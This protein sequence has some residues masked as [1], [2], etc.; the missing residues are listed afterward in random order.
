MN[1]FESFFASNFIFMSFFLFFI[2][3][4]VF[5]FIRNPRLRLNQLFVGVVV[6]SL[7]WVYLLFSLEDPLIQ[8][9]FK[10]LI[11]S[12]PAA[13]L[14]FIFITFQELE[15][16]MRETEDKSNTLL[17]KI[18][19]LLRTT[20]AIEMIL[21]ASLLLIVKIVNLFSTVEEYSALKSSL[22]SLILIVCILFAWEIILYSGFKLFTVIRKFWKEGWEIL[23]GWDFF[24]FQ[25][26]SLLLTFSCFYLALL[27]T[28]LHS[29]NFNVYQIIHVFGGLAFVE[30]FSI[31]LSGLVMTI[32]IAISSYYFLNL[33]VVFAQLLSSTIFI[34]NLYMLLH[35]ENNSVNLIVR[36]ILLVALLFLSFF[37]TGNV[38]KETLSKRKIQETT[39]K[40]WESNQT[41]NDLDKAKSEFINT[42]SH[43]LRSPLS[44]V[45]GIISMLI[46]KTY[47][48]VSLRIKDPLE[49]IYISNERL[50]NLIEDLLDVSR[51]EEGR[52]D[53]NFVKIDLNKLAKKATD[54]LIIQAKNKKLYLKFTPNKKANILA[55]ADEEKLTEAIMNLIDNAIKYT[56]RG[57]ISVEVKKIGQVARIYIRDTGIGLEKAEIASLFQKFVRSGR[58]NKLSTVGTG[59]GLYVV[60]KMVLAHKGKIWA[61]SEGE[62]R[63]SAFV[64]ELPLNLKT[65]PDKEFV[66]K[67]VSEK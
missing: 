17:R 49:K 19:L 55:F 66:K 21:I 42:A 34:L 62:N 28:A 50:I 18:S 59:L 6:F 45:K 32:A 14:L 29:S 64:I 43:Q 58:G 7:L 24:F 3:I 38:V 47:G 30:A 53:F 54:N 4:G 60:K 52:L 2:F 26:F 63:G 48:A 35:F 20:L 61:E 22:L 40:I 15:T 46:D 16:R 56:R 65:P 9:N 12:L 27:F 23:I 36:L 1:I 11:F 13:L 44:A 37:L 31:L 39:K 67:I 57:G 41:L 10:T 8:N 51:L 33:K 5:T 25:F